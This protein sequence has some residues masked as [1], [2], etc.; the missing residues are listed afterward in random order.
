MSARKQNVARQ[1]ELES[2]SDLLT[3]NFIFDESFLT[4]HLTSE[5]M[6]A[7]GTTDVPFLEDAEA[8]VLSKAGA[9]AARNNYLKSKNFIRN[10]PTDT[11]VQ[12]ILA[13][14]VSTAIFFMPKSMLTTNEDTYIQL[15]IRAIIVGVFGDMEF[16]PH[17]TRDP[18]P[19]PSGFEEVYQPD[20][21]AE[22]DGFPFI[23]V[24]VK[25]PDA[26]PTILDQDAR[27]V[28][29][30]MKIALDRMILSGIKDPIVVGLLV[31]GN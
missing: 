2:V 24:E 26:D 10:L 11:I 3:L 21:F 31:Q 30:M 14:M 12:R 5:A 20:F 16:I 6:A 19:T 17:W 4:S 23:V 1:S 18:L 29:H 9:F 27:K 13:E 28:P 7:I 22:R 25:K 8:L 15:A